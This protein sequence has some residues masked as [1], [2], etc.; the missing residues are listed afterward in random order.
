MKLIGIYFEETV[1]LFRRVGLIFIST[2]KIKRIYS[3][4]HRYVSC[5]DH[6]RGETIRRPE[7][8]HQVQINHGRRSMQLDRTVSRRF[9]AEPEPWGSKMM[10]LR[11][12]LLLVRADSDDNCISLCRP[13]FLHPT[14]VMLIMVLTVYRGEDETWNSEAIFKSNGVKAPTLALGMFGGAN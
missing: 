9:P 1:V 12:L 7:S 5:I 14:Q 8:L 11:R 4:G 10:L 3:D 6:P 2:K 13:R